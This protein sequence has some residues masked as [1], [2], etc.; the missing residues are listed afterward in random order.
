[1]SGGSGADSDDAVRKKEQQ[2][3]DPT[4]P[5]G[6]VITGL[7]LE[8]RFTSATIISAGPV[9]IVLMCCMQAHERSGVKYKYFLNFDDRI[10]PGFECDQLTI[11]NPLPQTLRN[12]LQRAQL[13]LHNQAGTSCAALEVVWSIL[14]RVVAQIRSSGCGC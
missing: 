3:S 14:I 11:P 9:L 1:M 2:K 6:E 10:G 7:E 4:E 8:V 5:K 13:A 12:C